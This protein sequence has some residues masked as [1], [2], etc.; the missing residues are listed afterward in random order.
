MLAPDCPLG[1][2]AADLA[3]S[4]PRG[5]FTSIGV[6][7]SFAVHVDDFE[8][9]IERAVAHGSTVEVA[10]DLWGSPR[11]FFHDPVGNM[12]EIFPAPPPVG[13]DPI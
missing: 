1:V 5:V 11:R 12:L 6:L 8:E 7:D 4:Y 13:A 10:D 9:T 2:L 3:K